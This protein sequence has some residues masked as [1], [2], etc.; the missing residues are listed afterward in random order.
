MKPSQA[1]RRQYTNDTHATSRDKTRQDKARHYNIRQDK[2][3]QNPYKTRQA[4][5][6][7]RKTTQG[8]TKAIK[9]LVKPIHNDETRRYKAR[10]SPIKNTRDKFNTTQVQYM[11]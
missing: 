5:S 6:T 3:S 2:T 1:K 8:N 11:Y 9:H 4:K 7:T 10:S